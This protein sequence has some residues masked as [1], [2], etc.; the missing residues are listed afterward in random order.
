MH[1][2]DRAFVILPQQRIAVCRSCRNAVFPQSIRTHVNTQHRYMPAQERGQVVERA[3]EL[4]RQGVLSPD[5]DGV[6]FSGPEDA[7]VADLPVWRD[8]KKCTAPGPDGRPC[9]HI[10]RSTQGIQKHCRDVHGW[11]NER[12]RGRKSG[13]VPPGGEGDMWIDGVRCQRFG[14]AG[15]LDQFTALAETVKENDRSAA[16]V[17]GE[18]SRFSANMWVRRTDW[19]RHL[20]GFDREWLAGMAQTPDPEKREERNY[21]EEEDKGKDKGKDERAASEEALARVLLA[22]ELVIWR[23]QR[24]SRVEIVGSAAINYISRREAG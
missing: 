17:I 19:P 24:A 20:R 23:A 1:P 15:V 10:Q 3:L 7:A 4:Q 12:A 14:Q 22:A 16:A 5:I 13:A 18:Q 9:G 2:F 8:G 11:V 21:G 6:R